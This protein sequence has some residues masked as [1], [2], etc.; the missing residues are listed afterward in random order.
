[1][2]SCSNYNRARG[3]LTLKHQLGR[4]NLLTPARVKKAVKEVRSGEIVP[5]KLELPKLDPVSSAD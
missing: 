5:L 2:K 4:I 3:I 1:M